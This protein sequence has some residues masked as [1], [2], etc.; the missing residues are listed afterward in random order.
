MLER[1]DNK[2]QKTIPKAIYSSYFKSNNTAC[3]ITEFQLSSSDKEIISLNDD[4]VVNL[5]TNTLIMS[6]TE[7]EQEVTVYLAGSTK[8]KKFVFQ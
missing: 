7:E 2:E 8:G 4:K 1:R 3:D 5:V 6:K